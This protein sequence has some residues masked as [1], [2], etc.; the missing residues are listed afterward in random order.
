MNTTREYSL[1]RLLRRAGSVGVASMLTL[2]GCGG[3]DSSPRPGPSPQSDGGSEA[4]SDAGTDAAGDAQPLPAGSTITT[5]QIR[6]PSGS[7]E[8]EAP[9]TFGQVFRPG[10]VPKGM[11]LVARM[12][13]TAIPLQVD[14]KAT[15]ADGSLRHAVLTVRL[16]GIEAGQTQE[17]ELVSAEPGAAGAAVALDDLLATD[18]DATVSATLNGQSY[19]ASAKSLLS[20][21]TPVS[22][23]SGPLVSEWIVSGPLAGQSGAHPHLS[24]R[25]SVREYAGAARARVAVV[26]E[27]DWAFEPGPQNFT[28]DASVQVAGTEVLSLP[29]LTHFAHARWRKVFWWG[30]AV[31]SEPALDSRYLMAT[32]ALP[33]YDP[34]LVISDDAIA[35]VSSKWD[36][37][38]RG[39]MKV[40][41][42]EPYMPA[43][44][45]HDDIGPLSLWDSMYLCSMDRRARAMA[46]ELAEMAGSWPIHYRDKNTNLPVSLADYPY[47]TLLGNPGDTVNPATGKSEAF[48][49]CA[50][51][52]STPFTPDSAHQPSI[53]YLPYVVTGEYDFLEELQFWANWNLFESNPYYREFDK[54]LL[55][56]GQ[57]RGQAWSLRTLGYAAYITPDDNPMK[58]YFADR[59]H[60]NVKWYVDKYAGDGKNALGVLTNGYAFAYENGRGVAPWQDDF[61][62][63]SAG[64]LVAMGFDDAKP[65]LA[66]KAL[67]P[68]GRMT[69]PDFCPVFGAAYSMNVRDSDQSPVYDSFAT[70]YQQT[71]DPAV[72]SLDCGS[73]EMAAALSLQPGE[74]TGYSTSPAGYPSNMQPALAAAVESGI[75]GA[76][77]AW[78]WFDAR[79]VKPD[80]TGAPNFAITPRSP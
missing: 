44:G 29:G 75:A 27:N 60:D 79:P 32:G 2:V 45:A 51:D 28:Y 6:N 19:G 72:S 9:V 55:Q 69:E 64:Q 20:S 62:T 56:W 39:P 47:M 61:F 21:G 36:A 73:P 68:V 66:F 38:E 70:V 1:R 71:V 4:G 14:T 43:T 42:M 22:W 11:T 26:V 40:G 16:P 10:D 53:A 13:D 15:H 17:L 8:S 52:C 63:W 31:A 12:G 37:S 80:Y 18:F 25:F 23:L 7:A 54:G 67:F 65:L 30:D 5:V 50:A 76:Q 58:T 74:M 34:A 59:L 77:S 35:S 78:D 57:V 48:P 33:N 41:A 24:A 46:L 49:A 3:D